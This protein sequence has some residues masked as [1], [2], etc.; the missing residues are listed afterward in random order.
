V[1]P[2]WKAKRGSHVWSWPRQLNWILG[3]ISTSAFHLIFQHTLYRSRIR[4][5]LVFHEYFLT[6]A[7]E[8]ER[9]WPKRLRSFFISE[10]CSDS[11]GPESR[12]DNNLTLTSFLF[13]LNRY[14]TVAAHIP[15]VVRLFFA[16]NVEVSLP[17]AVQS[18]PHANVL[19]VRMPSILRRS[20]IKLTIV[21]NAQVPSPSDL[22]WMGYFDDS[23]FR[24]LFVHKQHNICRLNLS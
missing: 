23:N 5:A 4:S 17:W 7:P 9:F 10:D 16:G 12:K 14:F 13:F 24:C 15:I 8:I 6:I 3:A 21:F 18:I 19:D 1:I 2:D 11:H 20:V 22:S